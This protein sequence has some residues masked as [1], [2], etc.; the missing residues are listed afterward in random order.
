MQNMTITENTGNKGEI[1]YNVY[2]VMHDL[3]A[4]I[5]VF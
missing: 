4:Y 1:G 3:K 2:A 5:L